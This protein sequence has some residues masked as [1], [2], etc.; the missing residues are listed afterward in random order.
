MSKY[1]IL[2]E[3][4]KETNDAWC[5][6]R[7]TMYKGNNSNLPHVS[8]STGRIEVGLYGPRGPLRVD[9]ALYGGNSIFILFCMYFGV[10]DNMEYEFC[11]KA[12]IGTEILEEFKEKLDCFRRLLQNSQEITI[13]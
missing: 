5:K 3:N 2:Y 1:G 13:K 12:I 10:L 11:E 6:Y 8:R 9:L 7:R 4:A